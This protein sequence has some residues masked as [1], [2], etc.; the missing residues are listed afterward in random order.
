MRA[1]TSSRS[2]C[3]ELNAHFAISPEHREGQLPTGWSEISSPER[4]N[5]LVRDPAT[6]RR[7][8]VFAW[9]ICMILSSIAAYVVRASNEQPNLASLV[10][11]LVIITG[12]AL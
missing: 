10:I 8:A 9:T 6:R 5:I 3:Q 4:E 12:G 11:F 7:Q 2:L 1:R